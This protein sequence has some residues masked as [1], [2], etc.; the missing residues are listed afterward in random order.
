M[1]LIRCFFSMINPVEVGHQCDPHIHGCT[2]IVFSQNSEGI[3]TQRN[4]DYSYHDQSVFIYQ[5][6][7][8]HWVKNKTAG[9]QCCIGVVGCQSEHLKEGVLTADS[10]L[11]RRFLE[12]IEVLKNAKSTSQTARLELLAGLVV[13]DLLA[14][15]SA[16]R[17]IAPSKAERVRLLIEDQITAPIVLADL[18]SEI[19]VSQDYLRQLFRMEFHES[20]TQ[21]VL[22][23]RLELASQILANSK[24]PIKEVAME[25]GFSNEYYFSRAFAK[26]AG[27]SPT[28]WRE[29]CK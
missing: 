19:R 1:A 21:Y 17:P 9:L 26:K 10:P 14:K 7:T 11:A 29:S 15:Q 4:H 18:A 25:T 22:R 2:E 13:C 24:D 27:M 12:F 20:I 8:S 5:P 3:L 28:R 6:G 16:H 23:R